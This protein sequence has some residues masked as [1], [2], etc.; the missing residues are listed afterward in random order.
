MAVAID[1]ANEEEERLKIAAFRKEIEQLEATKLTATEKN[2]TARSELKAKAAAKNLE[3]EKSVQES[4][5]KLDRAAAVYAGLLAAA[6]CP[7][8]VCDNNM[9]RY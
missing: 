9:V 8:A 7:P 2:G 5:R 4:I 6:G 1:N 3:L